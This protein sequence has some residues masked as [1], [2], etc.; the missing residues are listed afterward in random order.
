MIKR[1]ILIGL[2]VSLLAS[3]PSPTYAQD[4]AQPPAAGAPGAELVT[5][6][7]V[8]R[9]DV[10]IRSSIRASKKEADGTVY[11]SAFRMGWTEPL[12]GTVGM[13]FWKPFVADGLPYVFEK[14]QEWIVFAKADPAKERLIVFHALSVKEMGEASA[15]Q[16]AERI[17]QLAAKERKLE[18]TMTTDKPAYTSGE[19]VTRIW[20]VKNI[21][22]APVTIYIGPYAFQQSYSFD[23]RTHSSGTGGTHTRKADDYKRLAPGEVYEKRSPVSGLIPE[24]QLGIGMAYVAEDNWV[25]EADG[26]TKGRVADV[27]FFNEKASFTV[28]I[29]PAPAAVIE[30]GIRK[31]ASPAWGEQLDAMRLLSVSKAGS[32]RPEVRNM[33]RHPWSQVRL[34]AAAAI[35]LG[36]EPM[37]PP[38]RDLL[39]D[40]DPEVG[41]E[42]RELL[43]NR[44]I[45]N[46]SL[47]ILALKLVTG[48]A[49]DQGLL[50]AQAKNGL[51]L[52][53]SDLLRLRDPRI[54]DLLA[55][56]LEKGQDNG[57]VLTYLAGTNREVRIDSDK[58]P[59]DEQKAKILGAWQEKRKEVE[60][61][62]TAEQLKAEMDYARSRTLNVK[63]H[64]RVSEIRD[65]M[66]KMHD[67][68]G[69]YGKPED[70]EALAAMGPEIVPTVLHLVRT[71]SQME[72]GQLYLLMGRWKAAEAM[73]YLIAASY[74]GSEYAPLAAARVDREKAY[75]HLKF[76]FEQKESFAAA[77]GLAALGEKRAV[78]AVIKWLPNVSL[79]WSDEV[80]SALATAT[81]KKIR[82]PHEWKKWWDEEGSKQEWKS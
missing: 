72:S 19:T 16:A 12:K 20:K 61:P 48:E 25:L 77:L 1:S 57:Y 42:T 56:L 6:E 10:V 24:G 40:P 73:D 21:S 28:P 13:R 58:L 76:L 62:Y 41:K 15:T 64:P 78:P 82:L 34:Q 52:F 30:A 79:P 39:F 22:A 5:E 75:P 27:V 29:G 2:T 45:A 67:G 36:G 4:T 37:S 74:R 70:A 44:G 32:A 46:S 53:S 26:K 50:P 47:S 18:I 9:A 71:D 14:N 65:L 59:T 38:L 11:D 33:A 3:A 43:R 49:I 35:T 7:L 66:K 17:R 54:G 68:F 60:N 55:G 81:G 23:G 51:W 31:L 69:T 8:R 63:L 80:A